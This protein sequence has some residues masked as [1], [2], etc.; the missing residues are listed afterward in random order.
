[1]ERVHITTKSKRYPL[2]LGMNCIE[3]L[4]DILREMQPAPSSILIIS[5]EAVA[6]FHL[7]HVLQ[8]IS[9]ERLV[10]SYVVPSGEKEKSFENYYAIQTY[11]LEI[12]LDR[13]S[14]ILALGGG[15]VGDLSGFVAATFMRGIRFIQIPTT[16]LAHDSAVGGKVAVNHPLGKNMIGAFHQPEAVIYNTAFLDTLPEAEWRSGFAEVMKHALIRDEAFYTWLRKE[17]PTLSELRGDKLLY[18]LK[19]AI[20]VKAA[21][22]AEDETETGVRAY[23]NFGHTLGHAVESTM[24]YGVITHGDAVAIGMRFAILISEYIYKKE[25]HAA[26]L[27]QWFFQYG[28]PRLPAEL[29]TERLIKKMKQDKKAYSGSIRMVLLKDIG[30]VEMVTVPDET[31]R[32]VLEEFR[33]REGL[34]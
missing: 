6:A 9:N 18:A 24:G 5:D 17:I 30:E 19:V 11:A 3:Q 20:G 21:I 27:S 8:I 2:Y 10:H 31:V 25:L 22:V 13:N 12:G 34:S 26:E 7:Q 15:M 33:K 14:V 29:D 1:M 28:Y 23:L 32:L 16:L 4:D